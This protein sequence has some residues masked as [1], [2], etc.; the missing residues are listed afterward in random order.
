MRTVAGNALLSIG[1]A[2]TILAGQGQL[3]RSYNF[4]GCR[5]GGSAI[6][7]RDETGSYFMATR[8]AAGRWNVSSRAVHIHAMPEATWTITAI[9][10]GPTGQYGLTTWN[11]MAG[12]FTSVVTYYNRYYTDGFTFEQRV[13]LMTHEMGHALGLAHTAITVGCPVSIMVANFSQTWGRCQEA[14]PQRYDIEA[15]RALYL[16]P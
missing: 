8:A 12:R 10:L 1:A 15:V 9:D 3:D 16:S 4:S 11:C 5:W 2:A 13:S 14:W 7:Y 6:A